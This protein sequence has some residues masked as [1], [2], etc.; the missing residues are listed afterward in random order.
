LSIPAG[1]LLATLSVEAT[2]SEQVRKW[3]TR[4]GR[5]PLLWWGAAITAYFV[6]SVVLL[7]PAVG[8]LP[9]FTA[10]EQNWQSLMQAVVA[11]LVMVPAVFGP[12]NNK[13]AG[14]LTWR[15]LV[16]MGMVSYSFYIWHG[17]A[18]HAIGRHWNDGVWPALGFVVVAFVWSLAMATAS[19]YVIERP[20]IRFARR[21]GSGWSRE[22]AS[23]SAASAKASPPTSSRKGWWTAA[24]ALRSSRSAATCEPA[25]PHP[26]R[27]VGSYRSKTRAT[28]RA[29]RSSTRSMKADS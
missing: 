19:Y 25:A 10:R 21:G 3:T 22:H 18:F 5:V 16:Y 24:R 29:S 13:L 27:T 12:M 2:R 28:T 6:L 1:M 26:N 11:V 15:P 20:F 4:A 9:S 14:V 8:L 17:R 23:I 7:K